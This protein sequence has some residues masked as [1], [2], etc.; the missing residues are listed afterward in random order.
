MHHGREAVHMDKTVLTITGPTCAGK[1]TLAHLLLRLPGFARVISHTT[2]LPRADE[3][4]GDAYHF[5]A[6]AEFEKIRAEGGFV[7]HVSLD[8]RHYGTSVA[9]F[10]ACFAQDCVAVSVCDPA[11]RAAIQAHGAQ[12][13]W[14]VISVWLDNPDTVIAARFIERLLADASVAGTS[15]IAGQ[16]LRE[17]Y[18]ARLAAILGRERAW[19]REAQSPECYSLNF[20]QFDTS[21]EG[22]VLNAIA[23]ACG[24]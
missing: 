21:S 6:P 18:S 20:G 24:R 22:A 3:R 12:A 10:E 16:K 13:G 11:G 5:V 4:D 8:G 17:V 19:R 1:S 15:G 14:R 9:A 2:R 23:R 7:E